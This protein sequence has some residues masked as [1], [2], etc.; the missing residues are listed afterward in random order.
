M[1]GFI[2]SDIRGFGTIIGAGITASCALNDIKLKAAEYKRNRL[3]FNTPHM[4]FTEYALKVLK[5]RFEDWGLVV[6]SQ[7]FCQPLPETASVFNGCHTGVVYTVEFYGSYEYDPEKKLTARIISANRLIKHGT[8]W[9]GLY[10]LRGGAKYKLRLI[11]ST[12]AY[13]EYYGKTDTSKLK[14]PNLV[15]TM[16]PKKLEEWIKYISD[17]NNLCEEKKL[18]IETR[19][20][21]FKKRLRKVA[22]SMAEDK[23]GS[24]RKN[25]IE[26]S[27]D[28][29]A[30][31]YPN[32]TIRIYLSSYNSGYELSELFQMLSDNKYK[33]KE[34]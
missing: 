14:E 22:P 1:G 6:E 12:S 4:Y 33:P 31:G 15:G 32:E 16:T 11:P 8:S 18:E 13:N 7:H 21:N 19:K 25:G 23:S 10:G 17:V 29:D 30:D 24:I 9:Y 3:Y 28:L 2:T 34:K 26:Y 5:K 20:L 27:W